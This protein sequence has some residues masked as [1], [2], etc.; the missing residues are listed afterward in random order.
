MNESGC[1]HSTIQSEE[2]DILYRSY[3]KEWHNN[4]EYHYDCHRTTEH[5]TFN[6]TQTGK[7]TKLTEDASP[8]DVMDTDDGWRISMHQPVIK[9]GHHACVQMKMMIISLHVQRGR[10]KGKTYSN[11]KCTEKYSRHKLV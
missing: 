4:E 11:K 2:T 1:G 8:T 9:D 5:D 7:V 10:V 3:R 6:Y